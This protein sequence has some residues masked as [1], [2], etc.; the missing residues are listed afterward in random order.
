[1]GAASPTLVS[2]P[3]LT[4]AV[5]VWAIAAMTKWTDSSRYC[6]VLVTVLAAVAKTTVELRAVLG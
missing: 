5:D 6:P 1:M 2:Y 4:K 3:L